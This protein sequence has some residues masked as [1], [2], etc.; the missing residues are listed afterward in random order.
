V[1]GAEAGAASL[2]LKA[3]APVDAL[4]GKETV[5]QLDAATGPGGTLLYQV[6]NAP[7]GM[8]VDR[9]TG[10]IVWTP[11]VEQY[12]PRRLRYRVSNGAIT[13][14][15][16]VL[17][18]VCAESVPYLNS[19]LT[20]HT[21]DCLAWIEKHKDTPLVYE[22]IFGLTRMF[23]DRF[24]AVYLPAL[25][26]AKAT[27]AGLPPP[28]RE[29][30]QQ[31]LTR[32][33]WTFVDRPQ[34]LEWMEEISKDRDTDSARRLH[35]AVSNIRL[36]AKV[37][38]V[39][40]AGEQSHRRQL[41]AL[42][43][44]TNE[45][46]VRSA[47]RR[48][49][50]NLY[51][52][53]EDQ[54]V[55]HQEILEALQRTSGSERAALFGLLPLVD[56]PSRQTIL[57]DAI[58][59]ANPDVARSAFTTLIETATAAELGPVAQ[60]LVTTPDPRRRTALGRILTAICAR[61]ND[62]SAQQQPM[63]EALAGASGPGRADLLRRLPLVNEPRLI[64]VLTRL[65][66]DADATVAGAA[67]QALRHLQ[68][69]IGA[70]DGYIASWS[71]SGPY[72]P[73]EGQDLFRTAFAPEIGSTAEW[74]PYRCPESQGPRVV[75]LG[76]IFGGNHRVAYMRAV[77]RSDT[78]QPVLFGAGSDDGIVVW[79]NGK[80]I[81][82]N[83]V[84]RA[85]KPEEDQFTG[86]LQAGEN[87]ILCKITQNVLGWGACLSIRAPDGGPA[88]GVTVVDPGTVARNK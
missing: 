37:K 49:V 25:A 85:V 1:E 20:T 87:V 11:R 54:A 28:L 42:L 2:E 61:M 9:G 35:D 58:L 43:S 32:H 44:R 56:L 39:N 23:R 78:T 66:G 46:G 59:D 17:V 41:V 80:V 45:E 71:L 72:L 63:L 77:V 52:T 82:S 31:D 70:T 88:L 16:E 57:L 38:E 33:A 79:L 68:D 24:R 60:R 29:T 27:Y 30:V 40:V 22:K 74:K 5:I 73:A 36:W 10:R 81:H 53:A 8:Q 13:R 62:R 6:L 26:E 64:E 21:K 15:G 76:N 3:L 65:R 7:E 84:A 83:N 75:P 19:Y 86:T 18:G 67:R 4:V 51:E 47:V 55:F 34:I 14:E 69:E 12:G 50:K 48:A